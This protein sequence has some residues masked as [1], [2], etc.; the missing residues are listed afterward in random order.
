MAAR[1]RA[2][3]L[4]CIASFGER[5]RAFEGDPTHISAVF[6]RGAQGAFGEAARG[7][8]SPF[9]LR[10]AAAELILFA[11]RFL[12]AQPANAAAGAAGNFQLGT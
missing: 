7:F 9:K 8:A 1:Y 12:D 10:S 2:R 6:G 11:G 4:H 5:N 3:R